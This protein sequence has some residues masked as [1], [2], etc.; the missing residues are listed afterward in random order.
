MVHIH[1]QQGQATSLAKSQQN[2]AHCGVVQ[3]CCAVH[4]VH[5]SCLRNV[6]A[7]NVGAWQG[8]RLLWQTQQEGGYRKLSKARRHVVPV[9]C[10]HPQ[11][12]LRQPC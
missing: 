6:W 7:P 12:E 3:A 4:A 10:L 1:R 9:A 2:L 11:V 5:V 8:I